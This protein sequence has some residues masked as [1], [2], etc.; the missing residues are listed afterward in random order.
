MI[1]PMTNRRRQDG[2]EPPYPISEDSRLKISV[3][4]LLAIIGVTAVAVS[5]YISMKTDLASLHAENASYA[6][7]IMEMR[8]DVRDIKTTLQR[9]ESRNRGLAD[10][11]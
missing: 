4:T 11:K 7:Q 5:S 6:I 2:S 3:K 9:M 10:A 1:S 8:G